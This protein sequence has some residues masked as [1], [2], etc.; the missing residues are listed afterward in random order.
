MVRHS[1]TY[2]CPLCRSKMSE[3][4]VQN[5]KDLSQE[6]ITPRIQEALQNVE[7][8]VQSILNCYGC[9]ILMQNSII[10][11][12]REETQQYRT[13]PPS[14]DVIDLTQNDDNDNDNDNDEEENLVDLDDD[15]YVDDSDPD[16][17]E[18]IWI[19]PSWS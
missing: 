6:R 14:S 16:P 3:T 7:R 5:I 8:K 10:S 19:M 11:S 17:D 12:I 9:S 2:Q 1:K 15:D 18:D 4:L 13:S